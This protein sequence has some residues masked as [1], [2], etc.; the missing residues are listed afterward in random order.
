[1]VAF[2][3][4]CTKNVV[5]GMYNTVSVVKLIVDISCEHGTLHSLLYI[6]V[7]ISIVIFIFWVPVSC[8]CLLLCT[9][10]RVHHAPQHTTL[11]AVIAK[12]LYA[13]CKD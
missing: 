12:L 1:M 10:L 6:V 4:Q 7:V 8:L 5:V 2:R 11:V 9:I 3:V 13:A